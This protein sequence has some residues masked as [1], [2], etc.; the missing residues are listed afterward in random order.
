MEISVAAA[1]ELERDS[2]DVIVIGSG[3]GSLFFL[4]NYIRRHPTQRILVLEWGRHH[5][6][7]WQ[8]DHQKNS[9]IDH[10]STIQNQ[11][12][13]DWNFNIGLGGGTNCWQGMAA[14][15]HPN[16]FELNSR[17]GIGLDWPISYQD[18]ADY[19]H[20]AEVIMK[21]AGAEDV[22]KVFPGAGNF[23]QKQHHFSSTERLIK[24]DRPNTFFAAPQAKLTSGERNRGACCN[25]GTCS[26][27]PTGARFYAI[28]D[29]VDVWEAPNLTICTGA[30]VR[31][32]ETSGSTAEAVLFESEGRYYRVRGDLIVLGANGIHSPFILQQSGIL[33]GGPGKFLGEKMLAF[34][35]IMLDG[36][37]HFDGGT[38]T[39]GF[40]LSYI[41]GDFR[42]EHGAVQ[43]WTNN[44]FLWGGLRLD[45]PN[46]YR[47]V[48]PIGITVEDLLY[49]ENAVIDDGGEVPFIRHSGFSEYAIKGLNFAI[50]KIPE[51][52]SSLP[53]ES[54]ELRRILPTT[55]HIQGSLRMGMD[56]ATSV[57][58]A[59]QVHHQ[60]RNLVVVGTSVFPTT[61]WAVPSLTC[62]AMSL[63][64]GNEI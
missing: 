37:D 23:P 44:S 34:V 32:L 1:S 27:C 39:T 38:A 3:F 47:Q 35:E 4:R 36:M 40:E 48:V 49:E 7:Q 42:S 31:L 29:M 60:L 13:K 18:I 55:D 22:S 41:D 45:P 52:F 19:Y 28:D 56:P 5:S 17:Y 8:L 64:L 43:Y 14:R 58:D 20:A 57:V 2:W 54:I 62:A 59:R 63:K 16:D 24:A 61:S 25:N 10:N 6:R 30:R 9:A 46:R 12:E 33:G 11:G 15:M 21:V 50:G 26:L 51:I 53:I